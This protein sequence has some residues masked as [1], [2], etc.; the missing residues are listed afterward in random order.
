MN[1]QILSAASFVA[2]IG[3]AFAFTAGLGSSEAPAA[4]DGPQMEGHVTV[5]KNGEVVAEIP[6]VMLNGEQIITSQVTGQNDLSYNTIALGDVDDD[7]DAID[8]IFTATGNDLT[9]NGTRYDYGTDNDDSGVEDDTSQ[10]TRQGFEPSTGT[11][12][13]ASDGDNWT[14]YHAFTLEEDTSTDVSSTAIEV[15]DDTTFGD[16]P[17]ENT[18]AATDLDRRIPMEQ[19]DQIN[20]TWE[21]TPQNQ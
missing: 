9:S 3:V 17:D 13:Y 8:E 19:D 12:E 15:N 7:P 6:N 16:N 4:E 21:V 10:V 18:F 2:V 11:V 1:A 5:E 14:V 20:I